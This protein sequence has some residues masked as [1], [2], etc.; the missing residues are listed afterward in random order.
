MS[1]DPCNRP[2][3]IW[4]S[5]GTLIPKVGVHLGV[6]SLGSVGVHSLTFSYIPMSMKCDSWASFLALTF[7]SPC[8]G[9]EPKAKV[10]TTIQTSLHGIKGN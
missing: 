9:H 7:V 5:I 3:K 6:C 2:L 4:K 1:F 8:L 10:T